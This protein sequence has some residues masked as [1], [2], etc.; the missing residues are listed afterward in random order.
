MKF[1]K[2]YKQYMEQ[3]VVEG[4]LGS[5]AAAIPR[6]IGTA[7]GNVVKQAYADNPYVQAFGQVRQK[8]QGERSELRAK[9]AEVL[10]G[11]KED[12]KNDPNF[13][14]TPIIFTD[15]TYSPLS[16]GKPINNTKITYKDLV[17]AAKLDRTRRRQRGVDID[18]IEAIENLIGEMDLNTL[19]LFDTATQ[20]KIK[21]EIQ[22]TSK[23]T[24]DKLKN[25]QGED[26]KK[27]Q[28]EIEKVFVGV[29]QDLQKYL[30]PLGVGKSNTEKR[31]WLFILAYLGGKT[32]LHVKR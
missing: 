20:D 32:S 9:N 13:I 22:K 6:T 23:E 25:T 31:D 17:N 21:E 30:K 4:L 2:T 8:Q 26:Y 27:R 19:N 10:Q 1:D 24:E 3:F 14:N 28:A 12:L 15:S 16:G 7:V 29:K 5:V 18:Q 11:V